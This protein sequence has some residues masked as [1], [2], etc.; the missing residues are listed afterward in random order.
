[1]MKPL[2]LLVP[3]AAAAV[4]IPI[5]FGSM[6]ELAAASQEGA[7]GSSISLFDG[8][9]LHGWRGYKKP[10]A[11]GTRWLVQDGTLG[12]PA[13]DGQDTRGARDIISTAT[14]DLFDLT[15]E[16]KVSP[17]GN[18]GVKY[19]VLEDLESAIGHEYQIIDDERH[20]DAKVG[21][22]RQTAAFYDVLAASMPRPTKSAGDWNTSRVRVAPSRVVAGGTRVFHY[23][24]GVRVLEYELDSPELRAAIA[25]SKFKDVARFGKVHKGHILLQDHGDQVWYRNIKIQ[26][27]GQS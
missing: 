12:L 16:W 23:L 17:G 24:N 18:S 6:R 21:A 4:V 1:M 3:L 15:W 8:K 13:S 11:T 7:Q 19:Y 20:N 2:H 25:K 14:F 26:R 10:D 22:H 5:A 9:S 27:L